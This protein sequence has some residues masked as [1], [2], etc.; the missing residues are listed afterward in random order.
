MLNSDCRVTSLLAMMAWGGERFQ[1]TD[2]VLRLA[3]GSLRMTRGVNFRLHIEG[4]RGLS[5]VIGA[6]GVVGTVTGV[7]T[8]VKRM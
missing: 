4:G 6:V 2:L 8:S 7:K 5:D 3:C 1:I